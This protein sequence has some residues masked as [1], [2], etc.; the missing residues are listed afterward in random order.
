MNSDIPMFELCTL[1]DKKQEL[2][3]QTLRKI[4]DLEKQVEAARQEMMEKILLT[5]PDGGVRFD[6]DHMTWYGPQEGEED[7][8]TPD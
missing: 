2:L 6:L 1:S 8:A 7:N 5:Q 4:A 3:R